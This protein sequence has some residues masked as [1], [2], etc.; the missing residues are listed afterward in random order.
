MFAPLAG[1]RV[2]DLTRVLAGPFCTQ[3][4]GDWGAH[5]IKVERPFVG[6][7]TRHW[8]PPFDQD[9]TAIYFHSINRNKQSLALNFQSPEGRRIIEE[10]VAESDVF[11]ENY[12]PGKLGNYGLGYD[13]LKSINPKLVYASLSGWGQTGPLAGRAGYDVI[14]ASYGGLM[15]ITGEEGGPPARVGV[16]VT[17]LFTGV[18]TS[19]AIL[20]GLLQVEQTGEGVWIQSSLLQAQAAMLSH[21]A[22]NFLTSNI[23][24]KRLGTAHPSLVPYQ[25]FLTRDEKYLT[26]GA[27]NNLHFVEICKLLSLEE[28]PHDERFKN[29]SDRVT[30]RDDLISILSNKFRENDRKYW[31]D[32]FLDQNV[33]FPWGPVNSIREAFSLPEIQELCIQFAASP[34]R[35]AISVPGT[36]VKFSEPIGKPAPPPRL[37]EHSKVILEQLGY[38]HDTIDLLQ[39]QKII[40]VS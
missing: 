3:L 37:G 14:V 24:G 11:V 6:D 5:V 10:L 1:R 22:S 7:D 35:E 36:P 40:Q 12:I 21:I 33:R 9:K 4:L 8:G 13:D 16:A 26:I 27:G 28:I 23:D 38:A 30:N 15:S 39:K 31:E 32:V 20:A 19:N 18:L 17:D 29:N 2:V 34:Y 25:S